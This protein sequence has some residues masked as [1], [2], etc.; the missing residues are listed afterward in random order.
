MFTAAAGSCIYNGGA[1]PEKWNRMHFLSEPTVSLTHN[2]VLTPNG[3]TFTASKEAGREDT[4]FVDGSDLWFRPIH[5]RVGPDGAL[6]I[7]DFYN[8]AVVHND[9]RGPAHGARNAATRPDRDHHFARIW[10]VQHKEAKKLTVLALDTR[11]PAA[12]LDALASPNGWLR[13]SAHR[14][15]LERG[16]AAEAKALAQSFKNPNSS[17]LT[18]LHALYLLSD[19]NRLEPTLLTA[20]LHDN[21]ASVRK[22]A[23]R[24][25][26]ERN[27]ANSPPDIAQLIPLLDDADPRTQLNAF[28]ALGTYRGEGYDFSAAAAEAVVKAWPKLQD[29]Y[30]QSAAVG[31]ADMAPLTFE[32]AA[33]RAAN[34]L[35]VNDLVGHVTRVLTKRQDP[36]MVSKLVILISKQ[37][38]RTDEL[39]QSALESLA[40]TLRPDVIAPWNDELKTAFAALLQSRRQEVAA[41]ALP[42]IA[43]WDK[44]NSLANESKALVGQL[45]DKLKDPA[46]NDERR[47]ALLAI[48]IGV[49]SY[50][51][52]I[53][54]E[55]GAILGG[56][57][58]L[59][60][61]R[62]V[63]EMLGNTREP[64]AGTELVAAYGRVP[65]DLRDALFGQL[66]R[67]SDWSLQLLE[68]IAGNK[69]GPAAIGPINAHRLRTHADASVAARANEVLDA[70]SGP[71]RKQKEELIAQLLPSI[72]KPGG[73]V[74]NGHKL[75]ATNC[76]VCHTFNGEGR[77]LAPN[78]TGMG[79]HGA[80]ALLVH[81]LDPNRQVE[82]NFYSTSIET[83]GEVSYDGIIA[84]ENRQEVVL[85]NASGEYTIAVSD[86]VR[87]RTTGLSLMPEG[88]ESLGAD[89]LRDL[90]AYLCAQEQRYRILDLG[91][92]FTVNTSKG[93]YVSRDDPNDA[94][95]FRKFG[96][97][98]A[99]DVPFDIISPQ[100]AA[101][102]AI[103]LRGG[104]GFSSSLPQR[105]EAKIGLA[106]AR[107]HFLGGVG[108]GAWPSGGAGT[109]DLPVMKAT[110]RL[111]DGMTEEMTFRNGVEF[112]DWREQTALAGSAEVPG[113]LRRGQ[114]RTFSRDVKSR[115]VIESISLESFN[116]SI[117]P[118]I[119]SI[120]AELAP[121]VASAK[122]KANG[123]AIRT[124]IVGAGASH[125]FQRWF[126]EEDSKTL[127]KLG[128]VSVKA[129]GNPN[130]IKSFLGELDV[131]Y[132]SNN[133][134]FTNS[135]D[136]QAV[137]EFA[138]SG[139]GL[140]LVHP[141]LWYNW[142]DWPEYNRILC[143]GGSRGHDHYDSFEV[144][145]TEPNHPLTRGLPAKFTVKDELYW[146]EADTNGTPIRV[147]A[148]AHSPSKD[149]DFPMIF[150]VEHPKSRIAGITL[151]H[152]GA[153]HE[154][155]AYK[156][157]L[158]NAIRWAARKDK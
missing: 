11:S 127:T 13:M 30:I 145:V 122:V 34:P 104:E 21:D 26:A 152:D 55:A 119:M 2:D 75:F 100:A 95:P 19:L 52:S 111:A 84:R 86:I 123:A 132:L 5:T 24:I 126:L 125:D 7:L 12:W 114:I 3:V 83:R 17:A 63:I 80:R 27:A 40:A 157:L 113:I 124:L 101:R 97:I 70:S 129:T 79:A 96:L 47:G 82:P 143:G 6:Y 89:G 49:R 158:E 105:V 67:R 109:K 139:K 31:C 121:E 144:T 57:A 116:N 43:R 41:A 128:D 140:L 53:I 29:R 4:E 10:R 130:E 62:A 25:V 28:I 66:I 73:N 150:V 15:I 51:T 85:R 137:M 115:A 87:R 74:G 131:L 48:L 91:A 77:D 44:N 156:Q 9:T 32:A 50:D 23:T 155:P 112:A 58:S 64:A 33:F 99:G 39:K 36:D 18:R 103:V 149:K 102:N 138:D 151:G 16:G 153:V 94:P 117:A 45:R 46:L 146:F 133:A 90:L 59:E 148:T 81:I 154:L 93:I 120:T 56:T 118:T 60:T 37:E 136:R 107:L 14:L 72:Q 135:T 20:A 54:P 142:K 98:K 22:N 141:A 147:L 71:Q 76:A 78:L 1:W 68:A 61:Q 65:V 88:F 38:A 134:P 42:F 106:A 108:S 8:Q 35:S 69:V 92:A 110:L